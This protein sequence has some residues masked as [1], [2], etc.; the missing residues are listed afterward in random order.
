MNVKTLHV[1]EP[2]K[3]TYYSRFSYNINIQNSQQNIVHNCVLDTILNHIYND[4]SL[5]IGFILSLFYEFL[6]FFKNWKYF[7]HIFLWL[8]G[9]FSHCI[10][11]SQAAKKSA[12]RCSRCRHST[13]NYWLL[14]YFPWKWYSAID[15]RKDLM[16]NHNECDLYQ[17]K[18]TS[19]SPDLQPNSLTIQLAGR[20]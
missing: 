11:P 2:I 1:F 7:F 5:F 10:F 18:I 12:S 14:H 20:G 17:P 13:R 15:R 4:W 9:S 3:Y 6:F 8:F 19:V 16:I